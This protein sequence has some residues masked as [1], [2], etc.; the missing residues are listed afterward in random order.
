MNS[1]MKIEATGGERQYLCTNCRKRYYADT[2]IEYDE[3]FQRYCWITSCPFCRSTN[4]IF[5]TGEKSLM[6]KGKAH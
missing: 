1:N 5:Y 6:K 2:N 3:G 4:I